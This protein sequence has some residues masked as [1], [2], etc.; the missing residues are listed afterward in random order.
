MGATGMTLDVGTSLL[1]MN[2]LLQEIAPL[3]EETLLRLLRRHDWYYQRSDDP[4]AFREGEAS[5][6]AL[7]QAFQGAVNQDHARDLWNAYAPASA[8]YP[9]GRS[10]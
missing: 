4:R 6:R 7:C 5:W 10:A 3:E 9:S 1:L 2:S 8:P